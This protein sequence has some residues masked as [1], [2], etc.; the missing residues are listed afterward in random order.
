METAPRPDLLHELVE[1]S[2]TAFGF[3]TSHF[4]YT[5]NYPWVVEKLERLPQGSRVADI[6]AGV[7]PV[8]LLLAQRGIFVDCID[9]HTVVR[10][11]PC[12]PDWNEWGFFDYATIH[13]NLSAH[14]FGVAEFHPTFRFDAIY[15]VSVLAHMTRAVREAT[16]Q[17]CRKWLTP[18]GLL[19]LAVD[20]IP[21][22]DFLWNRSEGVEVEAPIHHGTVEDLLQQLRVLGFVIHELQIRRT[23]YRS[24]TDLLFLVCT[25]AP[26]ASN[27]TAITSTKEF[28]RH[29]EVEP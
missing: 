18:Q 15:S 21:A 1:L 3:Y 14:H 7:S 2:R 9:N 20:L 29:G 25:I 17:S 22:S 23:V 6:G 26:D 27:H 16:L 19:L 5:I 13:Q 12:A 28:R 24:R 10:T 11:P 4:P 8:P